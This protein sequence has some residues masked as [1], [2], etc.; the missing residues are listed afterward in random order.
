MNDG[1]DEMLDGF[2]EVAE[3]TVR[4]FGGANQATGF[5]SPGVDEGLQS[6]LVGWYP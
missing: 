5:F 6:S 1:K 2:P 4:T 3:K